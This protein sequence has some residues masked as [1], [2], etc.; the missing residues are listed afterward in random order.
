MRFVIHCALLLMAF[1]GLATIMDRWTTPA[2][3]EDLV[4]LN[5][6]RLQPSND[7]FAAL[8]RADNAKNLLSAGPVMVL[9]FGLATVAVFRPG[10]V[11]R[12]WKA[13]LE[14]CC[15]AKKGRVV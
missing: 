12:R 14:K 4:D 13:V 11:S 6:G 15:S 5:V 3:D 10:I 7:T 1:V 9:A 8:Q 2:G